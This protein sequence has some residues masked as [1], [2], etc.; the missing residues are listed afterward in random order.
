MEF[1]S[2]LPRD[3]LETSRVCLEEVAV[4][5]SG[6]FRTLHS[7]SNLTF[8]WWITI[9]LSACSICVYSTRSFTAVLDY[10]EFDSLPGLFPDVLLVFDEVFCLGVP[11]VLRFLSGFL[12]FPSAEP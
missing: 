6:L 5:E 3:K 10:L 2:R 11:S 7:P 8:I 9:R 4:M 12:R 1:G